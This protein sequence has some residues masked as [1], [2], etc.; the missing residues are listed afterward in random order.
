LYVARTDGTR[1][2]Y[3]DL[4]TDEPHPERPELALVLESV[5]LLWTADRL[6]TVREQ[7]ASIA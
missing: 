1:L 5:Y 6:A 4:V 3:W 2:G 7:S